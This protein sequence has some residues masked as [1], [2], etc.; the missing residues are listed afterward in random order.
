MDHCSRHA[1]TVETDRHKNDD[2]NNKFQHCSQCLQVQQK[3]N[4]LR[5]YVCT[6]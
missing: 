1:L 4:L 3:R 6:R 2:E 5:T